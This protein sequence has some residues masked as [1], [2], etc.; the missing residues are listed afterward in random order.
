MKLDTNDLRAVA[1][2]LLLVFGLAILFAP[3]EV[4]ILNYIVLAL[5]GFLIG[6]QVLG[7]TKDKKNVE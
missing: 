3:R 5:A 4:D 1:G 6:G 7:V 2:I